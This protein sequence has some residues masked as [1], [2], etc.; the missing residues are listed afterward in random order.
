MLKRLGQTQLT[1]SRLFA[2]LF[3]FKPCRFCAWASENEGY[4]T[5]AELASWCEPYRTALLKGSGVAEQGNAESDRCFGVFMAVQQFGNTHC[6][7]D[8]PGR[9]T[10]RTCFLE[11]GWPTELMRVFL[12]YMDTHPERGYQRFAEEVLSSLWSAYPC[13]E[14]ARKH[15]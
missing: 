5:A 3:Y 6:L 15:Q 10:L 1:Q 7:D 2:R 8:P 14:P 11:Q 13:P 12:R 4:F 9:T